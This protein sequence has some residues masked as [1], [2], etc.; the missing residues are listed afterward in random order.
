VRVLEFFKVGR[1]GSGYHVL[2]C[3]H[4]VLCLTFCLAFTCVCC[5]Y[6]GRGGKFA[7]SQFTGKN[8][9]SLTS[10]LSLA[11]QLMRN[12][13]LD[14]GPWAIKPPRWHVIWPFAI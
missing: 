3:P 1:V 7:Y 9:C 14:N 10:L 4:G 6:W 8:S 2:V 13:Q 5:G 11:A 12:Q